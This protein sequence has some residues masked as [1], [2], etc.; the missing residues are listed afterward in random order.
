MNHET[1]LFSNDAGIARLTFNRADRL[2]A[3]NTQG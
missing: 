3:F 1:I 2:N